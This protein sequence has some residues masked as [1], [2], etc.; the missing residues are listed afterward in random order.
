[1]RTYIPGRGVCNMSGA[2]A[3]QLGRTGAPSRPHPQSQAEA[4]HQDD[5]LERQEAWRLRQA[6]LA[7]GADLGLQPP[8]V[9]SMTQL[10]R[11]RVD[12]PELLQPDFATGVARGTATQMRTVPLWTQPS[13][14]EEHSMWHDKER[15]ELPG[16]GTSNSSSA[17]PM[18]ARSTAFEPSAEEE[19]TSSPCEEQSTR[20]LTTAENLTGEILMDPFSLSLANVLLE[21]GRAEGAAQMLERLLR[22]SKQELPTGRSLKRIRTSLLDTPK[23]SL[24]T[25][26]AFSPEEISRP[27]SFGIGDL[28]ALERAELRT[29]KQELMRT[30]RALLPAGG[31]VTKGK[32][33]SSSTTTAVTFAPSPSCY[34]SST[35]TL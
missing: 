28:L 4:D 2:E 12:E 23:E 22:I 33:Q 6:S 31:M 18:R 16:T 14:T 21:L 30:S 3:E 24:A 5:L 26:L 20:L 10:P 32:K 27:P 17:L 13:Q 7:I 29:K 15:L 9:S 8:D 1:M 34:D 19:R 25:S 11:L 35:D